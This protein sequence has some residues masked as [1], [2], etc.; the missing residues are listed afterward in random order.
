MNMIQQQHRQVIRKRSSEQGENGCPEKKEKAELDQEEEEAQTAEEEED[1]SQISVKVTQVTVTT[2]SQTETQEGQPC[3]IQSVLRRDRRVRRG[4]PSGNLLKAGSG[5]NGK[6]IAVDFTEFHLEK[7]DDKQANALRYR[8]GD[9]NYY[10][11]VKKFGEVYLR[12][13]VNFPTTDKYFFH[14]KSVGPEVETFHT[15][16]SLKTGEYLHC[17]DDGRAFMKERKPSVTQS[18]KIDKL[19]DMVFTENGSFIECETVM[20]TFEDTEDSG[21]GNSKEPEQGTSEDSRV[22]KNSEDLEVGNSNPGK[23]SSNDPRRGITEK[24]VEVTPEDLKEGN[25]ED[26]GMVENSE[27]PEVGDSN[28][29]GKENSNDPGRGITE[30]LGEVISEDLKEGSTEDPGMVKSSEDPEVGDSN[31]PGKENSNDP[32]RGITENTGGVT[33][34]T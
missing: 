3:C 10:L 13:L 26:S 1:G 33:P 31:E 17:G 27:D 6:K 30:K 7:S 21:K 28:E 20:E 11:A 12:K 23:E 22:A 24:L 9:D 15:F 25:T 19:E 4:E 29:P 5:G 32:G 2:H 34:M 18:L 14:I 8:A 16:K